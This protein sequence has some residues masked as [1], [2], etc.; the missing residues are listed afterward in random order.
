MFPAVSALSIP[1]IMAMANVLVKAKNSTRISWRGRQ[2]SA[3]TVIR[4]CL[5]T[6]PHRGATISDRVGPAGVTIVAN[7]V[8]PAEEEERSNKHCWSATVIQQT[9]LK[10]NKREAA[11]P[12]CY[13]SRR[14]SKSMSWKGA[15]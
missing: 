15:P 1:A 6:H 9:L 7:G 8:V 11:Q 5:F 12:R 3:L 2:L 14:S 4:R 13:S 10:T